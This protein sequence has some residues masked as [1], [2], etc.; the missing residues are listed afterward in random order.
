MIAKDFAINMTFKTQTL[1]IEDCRS[2]NFRRPR[3]QWNKQP[4]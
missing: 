3:E 2:D 1:N 4:R